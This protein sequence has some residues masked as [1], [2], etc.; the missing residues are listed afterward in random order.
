MILYR[1]RVQF[2]NNYAIDF[3][4]I[5]PVDSA[6]FGKFGSIVPN[7]RTALLRNLQ[8]FNTKQQFQIIKELSELNFF[9]NN[10]DA[11]KLK[12]QL[13]TRYGYLAE[14]KFSNTELVVK[15]KHWLGKHSESLK[16]YSSALT[17]Y[18]SGFE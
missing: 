18:E 15:T 8:A 14:E 11:K 10:E 16:Q 7:K 9:Q 13:Y 6:D 17:K 2:C 3:N 1:E 12:V 5:I 4:V